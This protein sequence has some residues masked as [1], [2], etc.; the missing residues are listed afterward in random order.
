M[1]T[2]CSQ[3]SLKIGHECHGFSAKRK[4]GLQGVSPCPD[5]QAH[6]AP[7]RAFIARL[8]SRLSR[9]LWSKNSVRYSPPEVPNEKL[10]SDSRE[11]YAYNRYRRLKPHFTSIGRARRR[12]THEEWSPIA[13][14]RCVRA[15][16]LESPLLL[17]SAL[18]HSDGRLWKAGRDSIFVA[19]SRFCGD[20]I[21][22]LG[23]WDCTS[24]AS[25]LEPPALYAPPLICSCLLRP[26]HV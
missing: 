22:A 25:R 7:R 16:L 5:R 10:Y 4:G 18:T 13:A 24:A 12:Q 26:W 15:P 23:H 9:L 6:Q 20:L 14:P 8:W 21:S 11:L 1:Y 2:A 3:A 19:S 17:D